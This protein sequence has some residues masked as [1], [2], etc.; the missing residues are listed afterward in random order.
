LQIC[1]YGILWK[2]LWKALENGR[3]NQKNST[4]S[5]FFL[6]KTMLIVWNTR[7]ISKSVLKMTG[8]KNGNKIKKTCFYKKYAKF[9][10]INRYSKNIRRL[11]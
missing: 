4:E 10:N 9:W 6:W 5:G 3:K 2:S 7:L 8:Q 11:V 1:K